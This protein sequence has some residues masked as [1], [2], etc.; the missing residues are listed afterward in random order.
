[1]SDRVYF[2]DSENV[3]ARWIDLMEEDQESDYLVFFTG[4]SPHLGYDRVD[5]LMSLPKGPTLFKCC[6]GKNALD[7][8]L[9]SYLGYV[10]ATEKDKEMI[11]VSTD[12][13][14][15]SIISFWKVRGMNI[16][17]LDPRLNQ[18]A[19]T[20]VDNSKQIE[21]N[22]S[23]YCDDKVYGVDRKDVFTIINCFET[24]DKKF[25]HNAYVRF[26]G[27]NKGKEIYD[28]VKSQNFSA[29]P[30]NWKLETKIKK[31][32]ELILKY[33]NLSNV[34]IPEDFVPFLIPLVKVGADIKTI[35][36]TAAK[37]YGD[38]ATQ[39]VKLFMLCHS[40][41]IQIK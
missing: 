35:Q 38:N 12:A 31:F 7:F 39:A 3:D 8:Q 30:V 9:V 21:E 23:K 6:E 5:L 37:K 34:P 25:I 24:S 33:L 17:R 28:Y 20:S 14:F 10:L 41:L 19:E 36:K 27:L 4:N 40:L 22:V 16:R 13:G 11:I 18:P 15:D 1:M 32:C 26:W 2:V 29:P